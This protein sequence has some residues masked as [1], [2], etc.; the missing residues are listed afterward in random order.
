MD[1]IHNAEKSHRYVSYSTQTVCIPCVIFRLMAECYKSANCN[2]LNKS[3]RKNIVALGYK[4]LMTQHIT[5]IVS[6]IFVPVT[7]HL[8][9]KRV[10]TFH[11]MFLMVPGPHWSLDVMLCIE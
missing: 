9:G 5:R 6:D 8:T 10:M 4:Y 3:L 1:I 11:S 7:F 2:V